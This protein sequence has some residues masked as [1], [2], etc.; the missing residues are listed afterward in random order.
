[1]GR[2][3][4]VA[5]HRFRPLNGRP[6]SRRQLIAAD[7][8][9]KRRP[10]RR[11]E[12]ILPSRPFARAATLVEVRFEIG[13]GEA[14]G[15]CFRGRSKHTNPKRKRGHKTR[16]TVA[17]SL[18]LRVC[19]QGTTSSHVHS[20]GT[21]KLREHMGRKVADE[22]RH[23]KSFQKCELLIRHR[24]FRACPIPA[25]THLFAQPATNDD[26]AHRI[27]LPLALLTHQRSSNSAMAW[28]S[29]R[30]RPPLRV[31]AHCRMLLAGRS[32]PGGT[33]WPNWPML[34]FPS[35]KGSVGRAPARRR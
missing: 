33:S 24:L 34:E 25:A 16:P 21:G 35:A 11:G 14:H 28:A 22:R 13:D 30:L 19:V 20:F 5:P 7:C 12:D 6:A 2:L 27:F 31:P 4:P 8:M 15:G 29:T 26:S 1:M 32:R 23:E 10:I 18:T 9:P 3:E 17:S